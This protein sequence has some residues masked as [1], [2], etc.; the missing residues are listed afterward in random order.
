[1]IGSAI[2]NIFDSDSAQNKW[3][4]RALVSVG[5][6]STFSTLGICSYSIFFRS[7]S[8]FTKLDVHVLARL[9][10]RRLPYHRRRLR[11]QSLWCRWCNETGRTRPRPGWNDFTR[12]CAVNRIRDPSLKISQPCFAGNPM[13]DCIWF[14]HVF[15]IGLPGQ[16]PGTLSRRLS[17]NRRTSLLQT[18]RRAVCG[19]R[20]ARE[21][22]A[23][24][25][26]DVKTVYC[27][28]TDRRR[29]PYQCHWA[30]GSRGAARCASCART[31]IT[32]VAPRVIAMLVA[33]VPH[34]PDRVVADRHYSSCFHG[35]KRSQIL[36]FKQS[37]L[38]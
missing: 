10:A 3:R 35:M 15:W 29:I 22:E 18:F 16:L 36:Q 11:T 30:G 37:R 33:V 21:R 32:Q 12:E 26:F 4:Q 6:Q 28:R 23:L 20:T 27:V 34:N 19:N 31:N 13:L 17:A 7:T 9:L 38:G 5:E 8:Y 2:I 1:M 24:T 25:R 14:R